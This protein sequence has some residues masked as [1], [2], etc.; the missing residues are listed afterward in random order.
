MR[1]EAVL[2]IAEHRIPAQPRIE[3]RRLYL[4]CRILPVSTDMDCID[5]KQ[6]QT[7]KNAAATRS[8][9]AVIQI[10]FSTAAPYLFLCLFQSVSSL[11][12]SSSRRRISAPNARKSRQISSY[13][14]SICSHSDTLVHPSAPGLPP[15]G[16]R[17]PQIT[18]RTKA[19]PQ[20]FHTVNPGNVPAAFDVRP[21]FLKLRRCAKPVFK[22]RLPQH[23]GSICP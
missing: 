7:D 19:P 20:G 13:P 22:Y 18:A 23:T 17:R 12:P 10:C 15:S 3:N 6:R 2:Q 9:A 11:S 8:A 16:L 5:L 14:R 4:L 21:H 1:P